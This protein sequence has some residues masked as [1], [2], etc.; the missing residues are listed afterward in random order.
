MILK[1]WYMPQELYWVREKESG[2]AFQMHSVD[3]A[4]GL[5]LGDYEVI[6]DPAKDV[7]PE[8]RQAAAAGMR[9]VGASPHPELQ[10][11]E[12]RAET[13][14]LAKEEADN[15]AQFISGPLG[16]PM[17]IPAG[18]SAPTSRAPAAPEHAPRSP[19]RSTP[20]RE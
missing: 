19:G 17:V 7:K 5:A 13:R 14:R 16:T 6:S 20:S 1:G 3:A 15:A 10:T 4:E 18:Q 11:P 2:V 9:S 8:E 12:Q